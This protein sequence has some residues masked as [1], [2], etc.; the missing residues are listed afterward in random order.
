MH[1]RGVQLIT[2]PSVVLAIC[3]RREG[4]WS[5]GQGLEVSPRHGFNERSAGSHTKQQLESTKPLS[6]VTW[7][8]SVTILS[9]DAKPLI[10]LERSL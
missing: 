5:R 1:P 7:R 4:H 2:Q 8:V 3:L 9:P 10:C 6:K